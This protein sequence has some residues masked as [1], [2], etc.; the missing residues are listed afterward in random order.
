MFI[1]PLEMSASDRF[2]WHLDRCR[3]GV[4]LYRFLD[5]NVK[6]PINYSDVLRS[7]VSQCVSALD[8]LIHDIIHDCL[9]EV[10]SGLR[11]Q[12]KAYQ[13]FQITT[14]VAHDL[15]S[16]SGPLEPVFSNY[17]RVWLK[18][19]SFQ[20]PKSISDGLSLVWP[21]RDKWRK[22]AEKMELVD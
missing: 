19:K 15:V 9:L 21:E 1:W 13:A 4:A 14:Q 5:E 12:T 11:P 17:L 16:A 18:R 6:P 10:F 22:I 3:Q 8:T 2:H 7:Q 20:D